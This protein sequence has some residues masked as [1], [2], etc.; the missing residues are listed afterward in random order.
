MKMGRKKGQAPG[1]ANGHQQTITK[2]IIAKSHLKHK[3]EKLLGYKV[4]LESYEKAA[5]YA[6]HK[7][8]WQARHFKK[9]FNQEYTAIV[10]AEVYNQNIAAS[11][12]MEIG[13]FVNEIT[14]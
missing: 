11:K 8:G 10:I 4:D 6:K 2:S 13:G 9:E 12:M 5:N 14:N 1:S 7:L 3:V